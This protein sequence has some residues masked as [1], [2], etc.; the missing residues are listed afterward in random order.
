MLQLCNCKPDVTR[1]KRSIW[2]IVVIIHGL[3]AEAA[4][5][6][7]GTGTVVGEICF[8]GAM[9]NIIQKKGQPKT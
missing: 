4:I 2:I 3:H 1:L 9:P 5:W 8:D 6:V 7:I